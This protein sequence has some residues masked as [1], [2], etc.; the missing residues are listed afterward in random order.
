M[1]PYRIPEPFVVSFSGGRTSA[2]MLRQVIDAYG[3][4][5]PADSVACFENTGKEREETLRFVERCSLEWDVPITWLEYYNDGSGHDYRVVNF[6]TAS[7][8]GEPFKMAIAN[9]N[10]LPNPIA[11]FC[12]VEMKLKTQSRF[13]DDVFG[14]DR[15]RNA[16]GLRADEPRRV[17]RLTTGDKRVFSGLFGDV[18]E[19]KRRN[20]SAGKEE[21]ICPLAEAGVTLDTITEYWRAS[22]FDLGLRS[23]EGN[24][25]LCFLKGTKKLL[26]LIRE[27]PESADWW[28]DAEESMQLGRMVNK[29]VERFRKDRPSYAE[30]KRIALDQQTGPGW[31]WSDEPN[32][33]CGEIEECRCTD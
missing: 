30:L 2:Y 4:S 11:R 17:K 32:G 16:V 18:T 14:W 29:S 33:T 26:Q 13:I 9:R 21:P 20:N 7:R 25:D 22:P 15:Y 23:D 1:N 10:M 27:R 24:C 19:G 8:N 3:G 6:A 5:L 28:I 31:L 12:T